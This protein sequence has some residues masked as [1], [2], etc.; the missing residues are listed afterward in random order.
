MA[1]RQP[2]QINPPNADDGLLLD[3]SE[4][5]NRCISRLYD[6]SHTHTVR[7][8]I[9]TLDELQIGVPVTVFTG[10]IYYIY[11]KV[12]DTQLARVALTLV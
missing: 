9:P 5:I 1:T 7:T 6:L 12:T 4:V 3:F 2:F 11:V 10:G 8:T